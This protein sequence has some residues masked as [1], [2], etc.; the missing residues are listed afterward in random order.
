MQYLYGYD[1][2]FGPLYLVAS[3]AG[4]TQAIFPW[5]SASFPITGL[6]VATQYLELPPGMLWVETELLRRAAAELEEYFAGTRK[7]F[8]L[9]L[10]PIGTAFQKKVWQALLAIPYG[11]TRS[12]QDVAEQVGKPRAYRAVGGANRNNPLPVFIPCHRVLGKDGALTGYG[13][14]SPAGLAFKKKLLELEKSHR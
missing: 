7:T 11:E 12:Y 5:A 1:L 10:D 2:S 8:D 4:L 14:P 13:G 3:D 9:P 6:S